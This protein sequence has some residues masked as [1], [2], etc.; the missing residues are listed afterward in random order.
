MLMLLLLACSGS[1][2]VTAEV[3]AVAVSPDPDAPVPAPEAP[4]VLL[5]SLD[6]L[7]AD[8]TSP[9][10]YERDTTPYLSELAASGALFEN[11]YSQ[12]SSTTPT[13]A[14]MFSGRFP[15]H[16][17][18]LGDRHALAEHEL[19][20]AEHLA[21]QGWRTVG[22]ASSAKFD[23]ESGF[24]QGFQSWS[25]FTA[26]PKNRRSAAVNQVVHETAAI[27]DSRP[28]F[29]FAHHFDAHAPYATPAPWRTR[30]HPGGLQPAPE[31][32]VEWLKRHREARVPPDI[33][34]YIVGLY[35]GGLG[36]MDHNLKALI[37]GLKPANQRSTLI[38]VTS[39]HGEAF[40]EHGYFGHSGRVDEEL[41]R[42]PLVISWPGQVVAG[43][44]SRA[45]AQSVDLFPT[46]VELLGLPKPEGLAGRSLAGELRGEPAEVGAVGAGPAEVVVVLQAPSL[47]A[48]LATIEGRRF[49]L[50]MEKPGQLEVFDLTSNPT[51]DVDLSR[52]YRP[53]REQLIGLAEELGMPLDGRTLAVVAPDRVIH[54]EQRRQ[55]Q[56]IGYLEDEEG[57][58]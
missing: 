11:S 2:V 15:Q 41:V 26:L 38:L 39:D 5:V 54:E 6:T 13:H 16:H 43:T 1:E 51:G 21:A 8:H 31:R 32:T 30:W 40:G 25:V 57:A 9:Y 20:L 27:A 53:Q 50:V 34:A 14:S 4:N 12:A 22:A 7:R 19:T 28:F 24:A 48:V 18:T 45:A 44:R 36:Y 17:G 23:R 49:K 10:G 58:D 47:W 37:D 56:A 3:A 29:A 42:V 33:L 46:V 35:D 55:L 52:I